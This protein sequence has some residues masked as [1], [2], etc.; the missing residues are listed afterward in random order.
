MMFILS[1]TSEHV[2]LKSYD[3]NVKGKTATLRI[4]VEVTDTFEL[5]Y[6][7]RGLEELMAAPKQKPPR[8]RADRHPAPPTSRKKLAQQV[9]LALPPPRRDAEDV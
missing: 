6:I 8:S 5:G 9:M 4:T 2:R 3:A 7:L 1:D